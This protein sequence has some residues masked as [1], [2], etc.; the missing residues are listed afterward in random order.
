MSE[1]SSEEAERRQH[2]RVVAHLAVRSRPL[3]PSELSLLV[4][5]LGHSNPQL[6]ALGLKQSDSGT[7]SMASTNLSVGGISASGDLQILGEKPL[8]KGADLLV[9]M[10]L[11]DISEPVRSI[12][13]V[14]WSSQTHEGRHLAGMMFLVISEESLERIRIYINKAVEDGKVVP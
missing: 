11:G 4:T 14:M 6:P 2:T 10:D 12:A 5:G 7:L 1:N 9:E 3:A 13:Q 8:A